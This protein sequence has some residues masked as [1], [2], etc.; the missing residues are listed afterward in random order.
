MLKDVRVNQPIAKDV[1]R[2]PT[3]PSPTI[4]RDEIENRKYPINSS[5]DRSGEAETLKP[6]YGVPTAGRVDNNSFTSQT[7]E[8]P[9]KPIGGLLVRQWFWQWDFS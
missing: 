7:K 8:E 2:L 1:F 4:M 9:A 6:K 5:W 3:P